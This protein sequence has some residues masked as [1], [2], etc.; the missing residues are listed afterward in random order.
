MN[1]FVKKL[2]EEILALKTFGASIDKL[3]ELAQTKETVNQIEFPELFDWT[4]FD[5]LFTSTYKDDINPHL[6]W[7]SLTDTSMYHTFT[8]GNNYYNLVMYVG[9]GTEVSFYKVKEEDVSDKEITTY[10][11]VVAAKQLAGNKLEFL[12]KKYSELTAKDSTNEQTKNDLKTKL[13]T[14]RLIKKLMDDMGLS[15]DENSKRTI[16]NWE[17]EYRK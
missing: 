10:T 11:S 12:N 17:A 15:F 9:Q 1:Y 6:N 16:V 13:D 2:E 7:H 3:C 14:V 5:T 4:N 8:D